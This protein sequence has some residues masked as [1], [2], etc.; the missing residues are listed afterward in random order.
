MAVT[1]PDAPWR[2]LAGLDALVGAL[3]REARYVGGAVRDTLLGGDVQDVDIAT[4]LRPEAVMQRLRGA[5]IK[6]VPTGIAHG[7][8]TAVL[9]GGHVEITTLR[10]DVSTD[11]RRAAVAF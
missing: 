9:E 2:S 10:R 8:V 6:A 4:P 1:L 7:T 11:G 3:D 5:G